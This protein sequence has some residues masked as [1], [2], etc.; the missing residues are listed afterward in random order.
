MNGA[1]CREES[2][3]RRQYLVAA[4]NV[5]R[6]KRQQDRIGAVRAADGVRRMRELGNFTLEPLDWLAENKSLIL[7]DLHHRVHHGIA[8]RRVLSFQIEKWN[9][10]LPLVSNAFGV[11]L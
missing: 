2:E 6:A 10:H 8:D 9:R 3:R 11:S 1:G 7:D 5:Q 4:T